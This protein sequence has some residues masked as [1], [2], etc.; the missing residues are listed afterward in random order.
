MEEMFF[1]SAKH[2]FAERAAIR[3]HKGAVPDHSPTSGR[4]QTLSAGRTSPRVVPSGRELQP[5]EKVP[6]QGELHF[7]SSVTYCLSKSS[8]IA[9]VTVP[10]H[11]QVL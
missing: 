4:D 6:N 2:N 7:S 1:I 10:A 11:K 3:G 8:S 9:V 5:G